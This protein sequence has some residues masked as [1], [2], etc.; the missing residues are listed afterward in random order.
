[1]ATKNWWPGKKV[2]ISPKWIKNVSWAEK[3]VSIGLSRESIKA[4]PEYT[5]DSPL[6][7]D[8]ETNL[9]GHYSR[10]GYWIEELTPSK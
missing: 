1:V 2:L 5:D 9:H 10:E 6:T 8:Y 7:R 3:E 4:A